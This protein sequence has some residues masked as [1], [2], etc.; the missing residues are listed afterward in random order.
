MEKKWR[1]R[2]YIQVAYEKISCRPSPFV[3]TPGTNLADRSAA[4]NLKMKLLIKTPHYSPPLR[5]MPPLPIDTFPLP[6]YT[7]AMAESAQIDKISVWHDSLLSFLIANPRMKR[8]DVARHFKVSAS[9]LSTVVHSDVFQAKLTERQD[10]YFGSVTAP[11]R[12]KLENLAVM[13]IDRLEDKVEFENDIAEIRE[14]AKMALANLGY[15]APKLPGPAVL[16]QTNNYLSVSREVLEEA[17]AR[18]FSR[19][20]G[21][22]LEQ[23]PE[24]L[25]APEGIQAGNGHPMGSSLPHPA[26]VHTPH[27]AKGSSQGGRD[28]RTEGAE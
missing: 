12:E 24:A 19:N 25:P 7:P 14:V 22:T 21:T 13:S 10:E 18:I 20:G 4:R 3:G 1:F 6:R 15:G 26:L 28:L 5:H 9:W 17:R 8:A 27:E 23:G 11:I 16:N 2:I